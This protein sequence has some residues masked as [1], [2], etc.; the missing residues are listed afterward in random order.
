MNGNNA[1]LVQILKTFEEIAIHHG[2]INYFFVGTPDEFTENIRSYPLMIVDIK[3]GKL[4]QYCTERHFRLY[5]FDLEKI[6]NSNRYEIQSDAEQIIRD[7][8]LAL[9]NIYSLDVQWGGQMEVFQEM[10]DDHCSGMFID[11]IINSPNNN[12]I[13]DFPT[14]NC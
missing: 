3:P 7:I 4:L 10:L 2:Q 13:C 14:R 5:I 12:G 1:S 8:V 6:D 11:L 9:I